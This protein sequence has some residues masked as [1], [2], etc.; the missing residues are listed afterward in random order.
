MAGKSEC[1]EEEEEEVRVVIVE[2]VTSTHIDENSTLNLDG[3]RDVASS[4]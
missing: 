3:P 4:T 2:L 1:R